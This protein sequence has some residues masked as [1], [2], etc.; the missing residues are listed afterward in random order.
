MNEL[1][2]IDPNV[3]SLFARGYVDSKKIRSIFVG[4]GFDLLPD[5]KNMEI[6]V[7]F[8]KFRKEINSIKNT[9]KI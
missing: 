8:Q 1:I 5:E 9:K 7:L 4:K 2:K 3:L 6:E